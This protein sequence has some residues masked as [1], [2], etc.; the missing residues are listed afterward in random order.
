MPELEKELNT[1]IKI[2]KLILTMSYLIRRY[3]DAKKGKGSTLSEQELQE[4]GWL[5]ANSVIRDFQADNKFNELY[6]EVWEEIS[7]KLPEHYMLDIKEVQ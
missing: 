5:H 7:S 2:H 3:V 6:E 4:Q 1:R